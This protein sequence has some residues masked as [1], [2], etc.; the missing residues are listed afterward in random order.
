MVM[1]SAN[2][3]GNLSGQQ[4]SFSGWAAARTSSGTSRRRDQRH[5]VGQLSPTYCDFDSF[6]EIQIT[7]AGADASQR[8]AGAGQL[9]HAEWQQNYGLQPL[10]QHE[11]PVFWQSRLLP[12]RST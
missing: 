1:S 4:T 3:G 11:R 6:E 8:G 10:L 2:V 5:R 7:T 9:H 12:G